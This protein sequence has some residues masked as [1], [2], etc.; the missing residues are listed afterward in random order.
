MVGTHAWV[1]LAQRHEA[2]GRVHDPAGPQ[3]R[4][5]SVELV[6][7]LAAYRD[8][9]Q[10]ALVGDPWSDPGFAERMT[11]R[12]H[13]VLPA[14]LSLDATEAAL[15]VV[16]PFLHDAWWSGLAARAAG[17]GPQDLTPWPEATV[18]RA[19][20]ERF[21]QSYP[22]L[23][24]R[25]LAAASGSETPAQIGWWLLHRWIGRQPAA[26]EA[27]AIAGLLAP[28]STVD[29]N[30]AFAPV[31]LA[32]L[33]RALRADPGFLA[34]TDRGGA[35]VG[36]D[37]LVGYL[38]A[39]AHALAVETV[40]LGDVI[41]E[42]LGIGDPVSLPE[43]R[44]TLRDTLWQPRGSALIFDAACAHPAVEVA[45]RTHVEYLNQL[46]TEAQRA[47]ADEPALKDLPSHVTT[48]AL[49][50]A[51]TG[52]TPVYSSAGV[53]FRLA[54]DRV[55][56][57]LMG[58][59]LYGD[60]ALAIRELYQNAL[61]ACRYRQA[62]TEYLWRTRDFGDGWQGRI[63][64]E[65]GT[66]SHGRAYLDCAD[67]GIGMGV[68]ELSEVFAQAGVRLADL[69]E[70]G[71]EQAEWARLDPPVQL[72]PNSRFG[73][74]VLSYFMLA[75]EIT[76]DTCRLGR[77]GTPGD[78]LRVAIAGP[79]NLFR[80]R[81]LGP[82]TE[83]GTTV[84][85]HLRPR[86]EGDAP[87]CVET[88]KGV[89]WV[90]DF[91]T[92]AVNGTDRLTW[93]PGELSAA[94]P[95]GGSGSD[96]D[97]D[98]DEERRPLVVASA[99]SAVW[100]CVGDGGILADGL[101]AGESTFGAVV[102]LGREL[103]PQLSVDRTKILSYRH[104]EV[105]RLL[106]EAVPA[107]STPQSPVLT[108]YWLYSLAA[109]RPRIADMILDW[110]LAAG[111]RHWD[112]RGESVDVAV[113]GC[114]PPDRNFPEGPDQLVAWRLTALAA[115]G[116]YRDLVNPMPDWEARVVRAQPSDALLVSVDADASSPW[117]DPAE[118]VR[119]VHLLRA[120]HRSGRTVAE[121]VHR[122]TLLGYALETGHE[123]L[124]TDPDDLSLTSRDLDGS[125]PWLDPTQP[126]ALPHL[127]R[128]SQR[129]KR[130][131]RELA[132][133]LNQLGC[134]IAA[135]DAILDTLDGR[136]VEADDLIMTSR[137][138]DG[139]QPWLDVAEPVALGHLLK[140][141]HRTGRTLVELAARLEALGYR[142]GVDVSTV[143][144][145]PT[146][147]VLISRDLDSASPWLNPKEPVPPV[148]LVR[149]AEKTGRG[150]RDV[151]ARL[152]GL[153]YTLAGGHDT[154]VAIT[155]EHPDHDDL[156]LASRD[157]DGVPP[158]LDADDPVP[159]AHLIKAA[160]E[161]R[162]SL[163]D[164]AIRLAA[165]GYTIPVGQE[166]LDLDADD[167]V[168]AS[169]DLDESDPWLDA[170][171]PVPLGHLA[172]AAQ[173]TRRSVADVA[174]RLSAMGFLIDHAA[175]A[176]A[177]LDHLTSDDLLLTSRDFDGTQPWLSAAEPVPLPHLLKAA[178][179]TRRT[180]R[181]VAA[182]LTAL[183]HTIGVDLNAVDVTQPDPD[184]LVLTSRDLDATQPWLS[185]AEPVPLSHL[186]Q[187]ARKTRRSI[188]EIATRLAAIGYVVPDLDVRL[189]RERPGGA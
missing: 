18:E 140:A 9:A 77:D 123:S 136:P 81:N 180:V 15:L 110:A 47:A 94:A 70:F 91:H 130:G 79:G 87:S 179:R 166:G 118:P 26:Y 112:M 83:A 41:V 115:A 72:H 139:A 159:L 104:E 167:R 14:G 184:D 30:G 49:R 177:D 57:L 148:H 132:T 103:A 129:T 168:L 55:Q 185:A 44:A 114:Y 78:L 134:T 189:P 150:V 19:S 52:G 131:V 62:R 11:G 142:V 67:N 178:L 82:G 106:R 120:A 155:L 96:D 188:S 29:G 163:G 73:I 133:R 109:V 165:L 1:D 138:L 23:N 113:A 6:R 125:R 121:V 39:A 172:R 84:R 64:F 17:V 124:G 54:E 176:A 169:R 126:V 97:D 74:G 80:I 86:T 88:L 7:H 116:R 135:S 147:L 111:H 66:D 36:R 181:E 170:K 71:E 69:P 5:Q 160:D 25:A 161:T 122:L 38:L 59:Q 65:Q 101:W 158:W 45:L 40:S 152:T 16:V 21:A 93:R 102:N 34:R 119:L 3:L 56:E 68:R 24:R 50:A 53:R 12:L 156:L 173:R 89:L 146:D 164:V 107:V 4:E 175:V 13:R 154:V 48:E 75:D 90:A 20:F 98:D 182:T 105:D 137:D 35:L 128:A 2:W 42:H 144:V 117:L 33:L 186:F 149:A 157:L 151:A 162:R 51:E 183:G 63:R 8:T 95:L 43:L 171:D 27:P 153:G 85:L 92:E 31:C 99:G 28:V 10:S 143:G 127:L 100:W 37:R 58:E 174:A 76:V 108:M 46:L 141:A 145:D 187:A 60:P 22:R 32:E 61:D